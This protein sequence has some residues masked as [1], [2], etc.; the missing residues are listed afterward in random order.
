MAENKKLEPEE[1]QSIMNLRQKMSDKVVQFGEIEVEKHLA[2]QRI[3]FLET[4]KN[5]LKEEFAQ[6]Q[7]SEKKLA[8]ELN[9][10]YGEGNLNL[11]TGEF[12][13]A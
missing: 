7:E 8:D 10:K 1:I 3:E 11:D 9:A 12:V 13:P 2:E 5:M 4:Q 6:M